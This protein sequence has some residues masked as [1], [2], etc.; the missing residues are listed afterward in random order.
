MESGK[1]CAT[2]TGETSSEKETSCGAEKDNV[3]TTDSSA[4]TSST[5]FFLSYEEKVK[6][7]ELLDKVGIFLKDSSTKYLKEEI[8][9]STGEAVKEATS[10]ESGPS[11]EVDHK[12]IQQELDDF[13]KSS[14]ERLSFLKEFKETRTEEKSTLDFSN[15]NI[16]KHVEECMKRLDLEGS[17]NVLEEISTFLCT[18]NSLL[19]NE[20][21]SVRSKILAESV[22][23][24][25][26]AESSAA[27]ETSGIEK[28]DFSGKT[29]GELI[30][31]LQTITDKEQKRELYKEVDKRLMNEVEEMS[32][33][34]DA[35]EES[36]PTTA[37]VS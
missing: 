19:P 10:E 16:S 15:F 23:D 21:S 37:E 17:E 30:K 8:A 9:K 5:A 7:I 18:V 36:I 13:L 11:K 6:V 26:A 28:P 3:S 24:D 35:I 22:E 34:M 32:S 14:K 31:A 4:A 29:L 1:L 25:I 20:E 33:S 27:M 2:S 12:K